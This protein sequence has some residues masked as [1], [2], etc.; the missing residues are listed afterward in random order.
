[1]GLVQGDRQLGGAMSWSTPLGLAQFPE[2]SPFF[3]LPVPDDVTVTRQVL[4]QPSADLPAHSWASL[5]DGTP[6][7]TASSTGAGRIIL[8]HVTA[9]A[10]WSNL[11]LSGLFVAML[12]KLVA[13]SV[14]QTIV[15][16]KAMLTPALGLD[17]FANLGQPGLAASPISADA[18]ARALPSPSQP[19]GYYGPEN[20]R[21]ALNVGGGIAGPLP[22]LRLPGLRKM[23]LIPTN[24][25]VRLD[26]WLL[27]ACVV[28]LVI[29][30]LIGM[31][32][33]GLLRQRHAFGALGLLVALGLTVPSARGLEANPNPA[34]MPRLAAIVT[35]DAATDR[36]ARAG[37]AGLSEY[38]NRHTAA[39]LAAPD[40][41][42]PG[43]QDLSFYPLL[44]WPITK[45]A[46]PLPEAAR[47]A[48]NAYM[49]H[50]G[51]VVLDTGGGEVGDGGSGAGFA[52]GTAEALHR[53]TEGLA[54]PPLTQATDAHI[55]ARS[56]YLMHAFPGRFSGA[57]VW[58]QRGEDRG[59]DSVSPVI[60][61]ANGWAAGWAVDGQGRAQFAAI[62]GGTQQR[63]L[64]YH[65]GVN[66][67]MY[68]LTGNYKG[69]QVHLPA[70]MERLGQ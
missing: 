16:D 43:E 59:N 54:I 49:A 70:I 26:G 12:R 3:G 9:N 33:R 47:K 55:L 53:V 10:D 13:Q 34:L 24:E 40:A 67:V 66:L 35:G 44:Y 31:G 42:T 41:V 6:L 64:G 52:P 7:V 29:D 65:F 4:A 19:P 23:A 8:F 57:P 69:D 45:D 15:N 39:T 1:V 48:L 22:M 37:L 18:I 60:I 21:L 32:L 11:P 46:D 36:L 56:F 27:A 2:T 62:P 5:K 20:G 68:A 61:G 63:L 51:I 58:V 38:V 28:L 30:L 17:G 25:A 50:G 14:G